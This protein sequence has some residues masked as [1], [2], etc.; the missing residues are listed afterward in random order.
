MHRMQL[1]RVSGL[2]IDVMHVIEEPDSSHG[3][4]GAGEMPLRIHAEMPRERG[5]G[6][7]DPRTDGLEP[8]TQLGDGISKIMVW[9]LGLAMIR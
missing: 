3:N 1:N 4:P 8:P 2:A 7:G 5:L 9:P 6:S